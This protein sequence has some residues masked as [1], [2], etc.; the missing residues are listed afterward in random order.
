[1]VSI[2]SD[3]SE[4]KG[5]VSVGIITHHPRLLSS[6]VVNWHVASLPGIISVGCELAHE[7][8]QSESTLFE[9]ASLSILASYY[10]VRS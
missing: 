1:M 9:Y 5:A 8:F 7:V 10:I 4:A 3:M 6:A 2:R